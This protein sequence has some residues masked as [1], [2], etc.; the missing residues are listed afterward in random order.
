MTLGTLES[1]KRNLSEKVKPVN[2]HATFSAVGLQ[3][4]LLARKSN[5]FPNCS[6][7]D[8]LASRTCFEFAR[9]LGG[10]P[11]FSARFW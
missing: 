7:K 8:F 11:R 6:K 1:G 5:F 2:L 10:R 4:R 3:T 9:G